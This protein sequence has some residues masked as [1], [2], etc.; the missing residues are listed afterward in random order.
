MTDHQLIQL[1]TLMI[2]GVIAIIGAA[3]WVANYENKQNK[4]QQK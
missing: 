3:F 2:I 1:V 4:E